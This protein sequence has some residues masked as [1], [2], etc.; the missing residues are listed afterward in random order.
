[1]FF[2]L[3]L[4]LYFLPKP[5]SAALDTPSSVTVSGF[6]GQ[7]QITIYGFTTPKSRVELNSPRVF[8]VT[9]SNETGFF[10]FDKSILPSNPSDLC[11]SSIDNHSRRSSPICIPPPPGNNFHT[12]IGPILLPPTITIDADSIKPHSTSIASGQSIPDSQINIYLYQENSKAPIFPKQAMAYS[13]P[14][15]TVKSDSLGNY[16]FSLPTA[17]SNNYRL[18]A[19]ALYDDNNTPKSNTLTYQLPSLLFLFWLQYKFL[20]LFLPFYVLTLT[21]FFYLLFKSLQTKKCH[22]LPA[23]RQVSLV[24]KTINP[25]Q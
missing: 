24:P 12:K 16:S 22:Y 7:Y 17:H 21:L 11:L 4:L 9:Y 19:T 6:I 3:I 5:V 13:L 2:I 25:I 18:F 10:E 20:I 15:L 1:M 14:Q 8:D 23:L